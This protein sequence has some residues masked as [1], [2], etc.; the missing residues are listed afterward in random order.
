M[1]SKGKLYVVTMYR[2][3]DREKHSYVLGVF[4]KKHRAIQE[5][6]A[7]T[8]WRGGK[9]YPEVLETTPD[10]PQKDM[11]SLDMKYLKAVG[12]LFAGHPLNQAKQIY[13]VEKRQLI[14]GD[15]TS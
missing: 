4:S 14:K 11:R 3:G 8:E 2:W 1:A 7:E 6:D 12:V 10:P 13:G 15:K 9:Y 5:G